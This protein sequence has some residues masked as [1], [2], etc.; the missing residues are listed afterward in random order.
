MFRQS[1]TL[2]ASDGDHRVWQHLSVADG[3]RLAAPTGQSRWYYDRAT[4][5]LHEWVCSCRACLVRGAFSPSPHC[6]YDR[7]MVTH[8]AWQDLGLAQVRARVFRNEALEEELAEAPPS[9]DRQYTRRKSRQN[10]DVQ[11]QRQ[12]AEKTDSTT[13][14]VHQA[15]DD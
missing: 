12:R 10:R 15:T 3:V 14:Q 2:H 1:E 8:E 13:H 5:T 6:R 9:L 7:R 11:R 4:R